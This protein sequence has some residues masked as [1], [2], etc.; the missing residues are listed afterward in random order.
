M[1]MEMTINEDYFTWLY[2]QTS[3]AKGTFRKLCHILHQKK[4]R[5]AVPND[6]NRCRDGLDLRQL[7][8]EERHLD[9]AHIEVVYFMKGGCTVLEML[10]GVAQRLDFL[11]TDM[12]HTAP[13]TAKWFHILLRNLRLNDFRDSSEWNTYVERT[14]DHILD[15]MLDRTYDASG[16]G[17][18]FPMKRT[19]P[20][21][22]RNVEIWYQMMLWLDE[23]YGM[24]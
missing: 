7:F 9:E 10:V 2:N 13:K 19:P 22:M 15:G 23:N 8:I 5:W 11:N 14:I 17:S 18:L 20:K 21:D 16:N 4:Y 3:P 24:G 1:S 12:E 6:D